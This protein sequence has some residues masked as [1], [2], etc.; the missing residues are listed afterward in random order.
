MA[1]RTKHIA[2]LRICCLAVAA[3][4]LAGG[5][6]ARAASFTP[7]NF[8]ITATNYSIHMPA[9]LPAGYVRITFVNQSKDQMALPFFRLNAGVTDAQFTAALNSK[10]NADAVTTISAAMGGV[11]TLLSGSRQTVILRL[12]AGRYVVVRFENMGGGSIVRDFTVQVQSNSDFTPP[13]SFCRITRSAC[14]TS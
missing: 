5:A 14:P 1:L 11:N 4:V 10:T 12:T 3:S 2:W 6:P 13:R 7:P 9:T 8:T